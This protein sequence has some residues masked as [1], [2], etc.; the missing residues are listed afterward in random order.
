[1]GEGQVAVEEVIDFDRKTGRAGNEGNENGHELTIV[2][3]RLIFLFLSFAQ[4]HTL[5]GGGNLVLERRF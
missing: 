5:F 3:V 4:I 2:F 1:M